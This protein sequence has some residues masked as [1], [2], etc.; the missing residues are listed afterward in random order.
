MASGNQSE[1]KL[2]EEIQR[3]MAEASALKEK[4]AKDLKDAKDQADTQKKRE[5]AD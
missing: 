4:A 1:E 3:L 2:R 5:L